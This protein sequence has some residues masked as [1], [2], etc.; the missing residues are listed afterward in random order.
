MFG[1][2][3]KTVSTEELAR[4]IEQDK[5]VVIDVREPDEFAQGHVPSAVNVPLAQLASRLGTF[6]PHAETFVICEHGRRSVTA[7]RLLDRVGFDRAY[8]VKGGTSAWHGRLA[9]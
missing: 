2:G 9:K 3:V 6:D 5:P 7:V 4:R 1:L 8:S